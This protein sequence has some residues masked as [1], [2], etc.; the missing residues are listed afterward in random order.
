MPEKILIK[1]KGSLKTVRCP[2]KPTL[3]LAYFD[4]KVQSIKPSCLHR[5]PPSPVYN[6]VVCV[7]YARLK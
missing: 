6:T 7:L 1:K 4:P 3:V 2:E 5:K